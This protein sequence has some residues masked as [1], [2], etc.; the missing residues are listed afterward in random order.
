MEKII[1]GAGFSSPLQYDKR[2]GVIARKVLLSRGDF[3]NFDPAKTTWLG[4]ICSLFAGDWERIRRGEL[5][6]ASTEE[7]NLW[8][9]GWYPRIDQIHDTLGV[10]PRSAKSALYVVEDSFFAGRVGKIT[11][12]P[13]E[14]LSTIFRSVH[15]NFGVD[16][17]ERWQKNFGYSGAINVVYTS[18]IERELELVL[19]LWERRMGKRI[20]PSSRDWAKVEVMY[21]SAWLDIL[22][23][24]A[25]IISEPV[26]H[27][28]KQLAD[29]WP[30]AGLFHIGFFPFWSERGESRLLPVEKVI[31]RGNWNL[32]KVS[33]PWAGV[34]FAFNVK[35]PL[36]F[37]E[38]QMQERVSRDLAFVYGGE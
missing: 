15:Q 21:T 23:L 34:N 33:Q 30:T 26:G 10:P 19:R 14:E 12:L 31:H 18:D 35:T 5:I 22:G 2:F 20:S 32:A 16:A 3:K 37:Q 17:I 4:G 13:S 38:E 8:I 11:G 29:I 7:F 9:R 25:G 27:F 1:T 36:S 24:R 28:E 6:F